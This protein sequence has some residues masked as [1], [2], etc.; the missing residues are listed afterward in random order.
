[1]FFYFLFLKGYGPS[2]QR[3]WQQRPAMPHCTAVA[4]RN[5][6][7]QEQG[8][9]CTP[10]L[11]PYPYIYNSHLGPMAKKFYN[12]PAWGPSA[13]DTHEPVGDILQSSHNVSVPHI[14]LSTFLPW[15][16]KAECTPL[17]KGW[18]SLA[19]PQMLRG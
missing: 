8:P 15:G 14:S 7:N 4:V 17:L 10:Q 12:S 11:P 16:E 6:I 3:V 2:W 13:G 19:L 18:G 1:M 5:Q 9:A